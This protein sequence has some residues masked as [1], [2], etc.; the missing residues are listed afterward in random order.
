[1]PDN[2]LFYVML[3]AVTTKDDENLRQIVNTTVQKLYQA[4]VTIP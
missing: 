2:V 3:Q 4:L 1:M